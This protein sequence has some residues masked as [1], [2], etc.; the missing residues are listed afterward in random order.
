[1]NIVLGLLSIAIALYSLPL[2]M[3]VLNN[4]AEKPHNSLLYYFFSFL[5]LT[6]PI[7]NF[8]NFFDLIFFQTYIASYICGIYG[9]LFIVSSFFVPRSQIE[10]TTNKIIK[11]LKTYE[12]N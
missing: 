7:I 3:N 6:F 11:N 12:F 1:M 4:K 9:F 2:M 5:F 10:W 8:I